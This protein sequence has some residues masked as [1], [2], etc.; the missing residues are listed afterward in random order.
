MF[1]S[2]VFDFQCLVCE[3]LDFVCLVSASCLYKVPAARFLVEADA[4]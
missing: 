3:S 1:E 2:P 4:R